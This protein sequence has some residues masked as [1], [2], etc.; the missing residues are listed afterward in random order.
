M[1]EVVRGVWIVVVEGF[2]SVRKRLRSEL[3]FFVCLF[4]MK[5]DKW[6]CN[7]MSDVVVGVWLMVVGILG[8]SVT[9]WLYSVVN[10]LCLFVY[11]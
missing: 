2:S 4:I 8:G 9:K 3:S 1:L 10:L 5:G 11:S 6:V 7:V